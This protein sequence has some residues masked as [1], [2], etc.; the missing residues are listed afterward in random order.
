MKEIK[1]ARAI[2]NLTQGQFARELGVSRATIQIWESPKFPE[3]LEK[4]KKII[5][6]SKF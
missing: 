6:E 1:I 2:L 5:K 4:C 3:V